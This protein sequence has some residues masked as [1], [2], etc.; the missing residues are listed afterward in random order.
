VKGS[1]VSDPESAGMLGSVRQ[2]TRFLVSWE[3]QGVW[4]PMYKLGDRLGLNVGWGQVGGVQSQGVTV[5]SFLL[6]HCPLS[7]IS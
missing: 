1:I 6:G 5:D 3:S 7:D 2:S 4:S